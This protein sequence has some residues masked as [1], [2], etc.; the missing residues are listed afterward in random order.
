MLTVIRS[1]ERGHADHG[2]L[3]T[4]HTFSFG[5]YHNPERM[6]FES[7]RVINDDT[8]AP[9]RGFSEHPHRDMEIISYVISGTLRHAD[10]TGAKEDITPGVV[11]RMSAGSGIRHSEVNPSPDEAVRLLQV[12]ILPEARGLAPRHESRRFPIHDEPGRLHLIVSPGGADGS[13]DIHQDVR[14]LAGILRSGESATVELKPGRR[15]WVQVARGELI[16]NGEVLGKGD[17]AAL[18]DE[19]SVSIES[20]TQSEVLV[21]DL[22]ELNN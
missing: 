8:V 13:M 18:T 21:F 9:A 14:M 1:N 15:A 16:V 6:G 19:A 10:S 2:W 17:A 20:T 22:A 5:Q 12:W 4:H 11:Q 7:L 3:D